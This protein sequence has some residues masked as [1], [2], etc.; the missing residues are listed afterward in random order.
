MEEKSSNIK[1]RVLQIA[2][3]KGV[4]KETFF[5][6]LGIAYGNF[7]GKSK[8]SSLSSSVLAEI[9]SKYPD[10][11]LK[12]LLHGKGEIVK[13]YEGHDTPQILNEPG[14]TALVKTPIK[15]RIP[16]RR[17]NDLIKFYDVDFAAG[18]I[19]FYD[20]TAAI[21]PAYEM[22]IPEFAGCTAF[23]T[24]N[25]S[26][27]KLIYSGDILFATKEQDWQDSL[28]YGQIYGIVR[29]DGRKFLKYIRKHPQK[30]LTH[31]LLKSEN[32]E[33]YDDFAIEKE[34]IKSIWLI[35]GWLKKR[36]G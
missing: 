16:H 23:R 7:K 12:W 22:D 11:N 29:H 18:D 21:K 13:Q 5:K 4:A 19:F 8:D 31:F 36:V 2:E 9:S 25:N 28:E 33:E 26:M 10:I 32:S 34:K 1:E 14:S 15:S 17:K 35:H 30:S 27:E 20:D 6:E 3:I 24:Y